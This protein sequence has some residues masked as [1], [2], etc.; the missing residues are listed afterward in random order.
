MG[1]AK[2]IHA[3]PPNSVGGRK[4]ASVDTDSRDNCLH[5][6]R[7]HPAR[8]SPPPCSLAA[9]FPATRAAPSL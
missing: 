8:Q 1:D 9:H 5:T 6:P 4:H 3:E 7:G 2:L